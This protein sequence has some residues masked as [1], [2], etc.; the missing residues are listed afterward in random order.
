METFYITL[1][2]IALIGVVV[3][4]FVIEPRMRIH[5]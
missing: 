1:T 5:D 2:V 3:F 4:L